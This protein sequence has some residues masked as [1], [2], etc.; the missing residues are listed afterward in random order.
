MNLTIRPGLPKLTV[1]REG[2][3][4]YSSSFS[5]EGPIE[6]FMPVM[7]IRAVLTTLKKAFIEHVTS[8]LDSSIDIEQ[9]EIIQTLDTNSFERWWYFRVPVTSPSAPDT[10]APGTGSSDGQP[11]IG[12]A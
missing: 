5:F 7:T 2:N 12:Q 6:F 4:W 8:Q 3:Y 9:V 11:L 10:S 1:T